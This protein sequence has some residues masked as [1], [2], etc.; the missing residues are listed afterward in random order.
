MV[1]VEEDELFR[2]DTHE[3]GLPISRAAGATALLTALDAVVV[4]F[5]ALMIVSV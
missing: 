2:H 4:V 5:R 3:D 1:L